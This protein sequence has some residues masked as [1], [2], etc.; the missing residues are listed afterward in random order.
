MTVLT[1]QP[2]WKAGTG[3]SG[4]AQR[5]HT[6]HSDPSCQPWE[7]ALS[8]REWFGVIFLTRPPA[9]TA[10][11]LQE[12]AAGIL[13]LCLLPLQHHG[14]AHGLYKTPPTAPRTPLLSGSRA[15]ADFTPKTSWMWESGIMNMMESM[16]SK[17]TA[18]I[19]LSW[20]CCAGAEPQI[21][22][23]HTCPKK[24]AVGISIS[25]SQK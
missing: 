22:N 11:I 19:T 25:P 2:H 12:E 14:A 9:R 24:C 4:M 21:G 15:G 7:N 13:P 8:Y 10:G 18:K 3:T 1:W 5:A 17:K 23:S 20:L 16:K 6:A